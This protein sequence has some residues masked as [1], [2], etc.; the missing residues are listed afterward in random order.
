MKDKEMSSFWMKFALLNLALLLTFSLEGCTHYGKRCQPLS[1]TGQYCLQST[2]DI[3]PFDKQ[4]KVTIAFNGE[5]ETMITALG[6]DSKG[7]TLV[8]LT[9]LGHKVVEVS[10]NNIES[11]V[12]L[13]PSKK[14]DPV[15]ILAL[16]QLA[17]WPEELVRQGLDYQ[18]TMQT[19]DEGRYFYAKDKLVLAVKFLDQKNIKQKMEVSLPEIRLKLKIEDLPDMLGGK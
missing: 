2:V 14:L 18:L 19:N 10:Y 5:L 12:L 15:L 1:N 9:P 7:M 3:T 13:T 4:Q 8:G 6:V 11:E 16:T 17:T